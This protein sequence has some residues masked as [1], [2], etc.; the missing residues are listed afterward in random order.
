MTIRSLSFNYRPVAL[1]IIQLEKLFHHEITTRIF[2]FRIKIFFSGAASRKS[3]A[4]MCQL[5]NRSIP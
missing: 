2:F 1:Y 4:K 3:T 5:Q